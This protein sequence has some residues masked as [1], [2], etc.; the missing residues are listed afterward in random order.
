MAELICL[1]F[2][3]SP[4]EFT[5]WP[6]EAVSSGLPKVPDCW[7]QGALELDVD[8]LNHGAI[9]DNGGSLPDIRGIE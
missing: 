8:R 3:I 5:G 1:V 4:G 2:L 6:R 7:T 9:W